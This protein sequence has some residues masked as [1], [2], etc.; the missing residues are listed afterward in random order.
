M[1]EDA[2]IKTLQ[3]SLAMAIRLG[4]KIQQRLDEVTGRAGDLRVRLLSDQD[5][6]TLS[7]ALGNITA[8][9]LIKPAVMERIAARLDGREWK[10]SRE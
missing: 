10:E 4:E 3:D 7:L 2:H 8:Q 6:A 5:I 1:A 9:E